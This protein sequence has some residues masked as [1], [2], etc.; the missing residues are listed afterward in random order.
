MPAF[1]IVIP[2]HNEEQY[3][4]E[5]LATI[6]QQ[7]DQDYE[8]IVV[9]N[10]CTDNTAK[11]AQQHS[12]VKHYNSPHAHVS[13]ARNYGAGKAQGD[14]LVFLDADTKLEN[15]ALTKIRDHFQDNH[16]VATTKVKPDIKKAKYSFAM[17]FK[18][19]YNSTGIYK[20]CSGVLICKKKDFESV[21]GYHPEL[22]VK[23][24]RDVTK[25]LLEKGSYTCIPTYATTAMR[26][27]EQWGLTKATWFWV[28]Q[29]GKNLVK[30][31]TKTDYEKIR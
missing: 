13:R 4:A 16:S 14:I 30:P 9:T 22:K 20:G 18:N 3:L 5:T 8:T 25:R 10:G 6:K 2:A 15:D 7:T 29:W 11:I 19:W 28:K 31:V 26:R 24:H 17:A 1:S 27:F 23:E 12:W 21:N